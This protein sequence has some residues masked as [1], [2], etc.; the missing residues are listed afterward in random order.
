M[1]YMSSFNNIHN[2]ITFWDEPTISMDYDEHPCHEII[3]QNWKENIIPNMILS[4]ATLPKQH[5]I[6]S[7]IQDF[8][9]K[10]DGTISESESSYA[11]KV[12]SILSDDCKKTISLINTDG[13]VELPHLKYSD[14]DKILT[15]V[16]HCQQYPTLL[17]YFD[18]QEVSA[19]IYYIHINNLCTRELYSFE[20]VFPSLH[21]VNMKNIK[22]H[23][24][25][26]LKNIDQNN[27]KNIYDYFQK[28]REYA[29][30]ART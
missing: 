17:R 11:I 26:I 15:S 6:M 9:G 16:S 12:H 19:F 3:K 7:V 1:Y 20:N 8:T 13:Y 14:Y 30:R 18:L 25:N 22:L 23:Y 24:L 4:S 10:F 27:W 21:D 28:T 5:E 2:I 29:R